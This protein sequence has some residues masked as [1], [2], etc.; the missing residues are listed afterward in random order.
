M[1]ACRRTLQFMLSHLNVVAGE[2]KEN[3]MHFGNLA[4]M[5]GPS[6]SWPNDPAK[7]NKNPVLLI[8]QNKVIQFLLENMDKLKLT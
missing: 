3:Q 5:L 7:I 8:K 2:A 6:M 1:T 4:M